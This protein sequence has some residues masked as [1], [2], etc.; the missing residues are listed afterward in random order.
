[1]PASFDGRHTA[2]LVFLHGFTQTH[3]HWHRV[4]LSVADAVG[5]S[6]PRTRPTLAFV[7]L[8]GHGLSNE[9]RST[10]EDAA[11]RL[12]L[13]AGAGTYV[14]Y[15]MGARFAL[16]SA[17]TGAAAIERLVLV[18]GTPGIDD[19][20]ERRD[21]AGADAERADSI[22]RDGVAT[23]LDGWL[24]APMFAGLPPDA[25]GLAHR[26]RNNAVGLAHSLRAFGTGNQ[27]SFWHRLDQI[28]IPVLVI[29]GDVD[30]K[31][32]E[33]GTRM[34]ERLPRGSFAS[35]AG[36]GHAAHIEQPELVTA[37]IGDWLVST[38]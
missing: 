12:P 31:F 15:S 27:P 35:I 14:G 30:V 29:A 5:H 37:V 10:I 20:A 1:M 11:D 4:A 24:T 2:R 3:H 18:G 38:G 32:T 17:A 19:A 25:D 28:E 23:F 13:L 34:A 9:D 16:V 8:P 26:L 7:D 33:I 6:A 21:R 36:S 22:E